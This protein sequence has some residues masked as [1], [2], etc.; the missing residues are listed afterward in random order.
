MSDKK[1]VRATKFKPEWVSALGAEKW[2]SIGSCPTK[3]RCVRCGEFSVAQQGITAVKQHAES[4]KH[5]V[6]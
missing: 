6:M 5:K 3:A 1:A 4:E 2:L